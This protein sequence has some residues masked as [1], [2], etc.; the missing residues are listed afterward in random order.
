MLK[1]LNKQP[2]LTK[3][4]KIEKNQ[5]S[6]INAKTKKEQK[7]FCLILNLYKSF[8][9]CYKANLLLQLIDCEL[10]Y[11]L[12]LLKNLTVWTIFLLLLYFKQAVVWKLQ[13]DLMIMFTLKQVY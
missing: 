5:T 10:F 4:K 8:Y 1:E 12:S 6:K 2:E 13:I 3:Q 7:N 9:A 11:L